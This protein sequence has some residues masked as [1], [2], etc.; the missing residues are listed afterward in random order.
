MKEGDAAVPLPMWVENKCVFITFS[1]RPV[2]TSRV[3]FLESVAKG[4]WLTGFPLRQN[5]RQMI[6]VN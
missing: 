6:F 4:C 1:L 2:A 3:A 5:Q